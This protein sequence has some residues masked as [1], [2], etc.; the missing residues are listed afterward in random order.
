[1]F[2]REEVRLEAAFGEALEGLARLPD[3]SRL[4]NASRA[5]YRDGIRG[6]ARV[7]PTGGWPGVSKLVTVEVGD[8]IAHDDSASLPLR[9]QAIGP[10]SRLFPALDADIILSPDGESA[11]T[12]TL[13]GVYRPPLG[14]LGV[15]L[16]RALLSHVATATIRDFVGRLAAAPLD[17]S[18]GA[19]QQGV[20]S[21]RR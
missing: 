17:R 12:M 1:M 21:D 11:T 3:G 4:L 2:V 20:D 19:Q 7:G 5:A 10:G 14:S 6:Q 18:G 15:M 16:D 9:W 13:A 8:L